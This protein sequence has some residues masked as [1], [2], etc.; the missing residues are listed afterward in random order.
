MGPTGDISSPTAEHD[1]CQASATPSM[2]LGSLM[3]SNWGTIDSSEL[4]IIIED[5]IGT[6]RNE[7]EWR[8][9]A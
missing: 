3:R 8:H 1:G 4:R 7:I 2:T 5:R 6:L 9:Q